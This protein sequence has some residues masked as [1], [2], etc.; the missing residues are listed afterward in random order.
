[1]RKAR[2]QAVRIFD[3]WITTA[4]PIG[5][6]NALERL[7][8]KFAGKDWSFQFELEDEDEGE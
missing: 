8:R 1:M 6:V 3:F 5:F 7:T 4:R 2:K